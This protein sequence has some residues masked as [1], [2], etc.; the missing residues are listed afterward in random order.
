MREIEVIVDTDEIREYMFEKLISKGY[1]ATDDESHMLA[2]IVFD[3][4][5]HKEII[6][7]ETN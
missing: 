3:Y 4:L 5:V 6:D 1:V 7:E 2:H